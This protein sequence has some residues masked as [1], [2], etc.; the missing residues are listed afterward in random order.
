[1]QEKKTQLCYNKYMKILYVSTSTD[2]GGAETS[3]R[4][5]AL[6]AQMAGHEVK[7]ISFFSY[8]HLQLHQQQT[9]KK[10][11]D[12]KQLTFHNCQNI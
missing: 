6:V 10:Y 1:M 8:L 4:A 12:L 7:V 11:P 2:M 9:I 5:L 3:L